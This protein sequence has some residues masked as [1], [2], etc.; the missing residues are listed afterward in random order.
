MRAG[1]APPLEHVDLHVDDGEFVCLLGAS[2]CGKSTLLRIIG[3]LEQPT[4]GAVHV[5]GDLVVG[6]GPD[7]GHGVPGATRCSRG[8]RSP[9]TSRSGSSARRCRKAR[10]QERVDEL[11]GIMGAHAS[12]PTACPNELSGGM[13]QRV[14]IARALAPEPDVLLLDEPFG[15]STRRRAARCRTSCSRCGGAPARRSC[16]S[17]TT[18]RR[19]LPRASGSTCS[20]RPRAGAPII[21]VPFGA[22]PRPGVKPRPALPR[23]PRRDRGPPRLRGGG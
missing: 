2:G 1:P 18:S 22:E 3:G 23:P 4:A 12:S 9:R 14:A 10:R 21:D 20:R 15:A 8:G 11:L 16:S 7:R 17:P 6:P 5:D 19:R 13:R